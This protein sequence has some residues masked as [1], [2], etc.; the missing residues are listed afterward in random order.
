MTSQNNGN[1]TITKKGSMH[2]F[3]TEYYGFVNSSYFQCNLFL[4]GYDPTVIDMQFFRTMDN[5]NEKNPGV[6]ISR[7]REKPVITFTRVPVQKKQDYS[8]PKSKPK[9]LHRYDV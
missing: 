4:E 2:T 8:K 9:H 3:G 6:L 5:L 1:G 7:D